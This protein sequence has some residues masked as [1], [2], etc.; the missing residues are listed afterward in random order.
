M[1]KEFSG[2]RAWFKWWST[3]EY[4]TLSSVP[5]TAKKKKKKRKEKGGREGER[6]GERKGGREGG[7]FQRTVL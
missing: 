4:Q 7:I 2:L 3:S 1:R 6:E 5:S